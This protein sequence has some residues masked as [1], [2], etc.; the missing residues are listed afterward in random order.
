[1]QA[2]IDPSGAT[3]YESAMLV[4]IRRHAPFEQDFSKFCIHGIVSLLCG[5]S[6]RH[7]RDYYTL[8]PSMTLIK[9]RMGTVSQ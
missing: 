9:P 3:R 6:P 4:A 5:A 1:M 8:W 2:Y 7:V